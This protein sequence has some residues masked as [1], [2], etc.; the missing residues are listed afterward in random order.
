MC[1]KAGMQFSRF[2]LF[3]PQLTVDKHNEGNIAN[4][5]GNQV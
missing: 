3:L 4:V 2:L 1:N 5:Q